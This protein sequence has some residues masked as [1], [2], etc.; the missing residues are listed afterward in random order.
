MPDPRWS[1]EWRV[2]LERQLQQVARREADASSLARLVAAYVEAAKAN[3]R[4]SEQVI[5]SLK[6]ITTPAIRTYA[7]T[8]DWVRLNN[9]IFQWCLDAYYGPT[10]VRDDRDSTSASPGT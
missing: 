1:E 2:L 9:D 3:G 10:R 7:P 6:E 4:A 5:R 8:E